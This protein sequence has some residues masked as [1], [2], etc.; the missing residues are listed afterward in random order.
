M[1]EGPEVRVTLTAEDAGVAAAIRE[2]NS[3]LKTLKTTQDRVTEST[4][5]SAGAFKS[6]AAQA[7]SAVKLRLAN[8]PG[9][10]GWGSAVALRAYEPIGKELE[11]GAGA[12]EERFGAAAIAVGGV[13]AAV[14][15]LGVAA[16]AV[17]HRM[18]ELEQSIE[19]TAAATG[20]STTQVQEFTEL[21]REMD[22]D[23][24]TLQ[25]AF[26]RMQVQLGEFMTTGKA[27]GDGS[28]YMAK[29]LSA[30]GISLADAHGNVRPLNDI[31]GDFFVILQKMPNAEARAALEAEV[32]GTRGRVLTEVFE[33]AI[34]EGTS[35][36]DVLDRIGKTGPV[37]PESELRELAQAEK[38]WEDLT[39]AALGYWT[40]LKVAMTTTVLHPVKSAEYLGGMAAL[41]TA[42]PAAAADKALS[43][44]RAQRDA[45]VAEISK[46]TPTGGATNV[47]AVMQATALN[48]T[49]KTELETL[50][51]GSKEQLELKQAEAHYAAA[52]KAHDTV[53]IG[54]YAEQISMLRQIVGLKQKVSHAAPEQA[55]KAEL[56]LGL[57]QQ[58][59]LL[60]TWKEGAA[61]RAE[62]DQESYERGTLSLEDYFAGRRAAVAEETRKEIEV[63]K[64]NRRQVEAASAE[65]GGRAS[66]AQSVLARMSPYGKPEKR[67][68]EAALVDRY[69]AE[70]LKYLE[71]IDGLNAQISI[72][73]IEAKTKFIEL[74]AQEFSTQRAQKEKVLEFIRQIE[75]LQGNVN[76]GAAAQVEARTEQMRSTLEQLRGQ[77]VGGTTLSEAN[78]NAMLSKYTNVAMAVASFSDLEKNTQQAIA[79][80]EIRKSTIETKLHDNLI[81]RVAAQQE[82]RR[83][84][85]TEIPI[86]RQKARLELE[87]AKAT[88][89][90]GKILQAQEALL[91]IQ[92]KSTQQ[93]ETYKTVLHGV[94]GTLRQ[95]FQTMFDAIGKGARSV[96]LAFGQMELGVI[97]SLENVATGLAS[98]LAVALMTDELWRISDAKTAASGAFK[99]AIH[100]LPFPINI[101]VAFASA[102]IAFEGAL[103]YAEGGL[104]DGPGGPTA[105]RVPAMLSS[106]E[107]VLR[108][109]AVDAF[110]K[111]N[112]DAINAGIATTRPGFASSIASL[113]DL[114]MPTVTF[115]D[116][117]GG[118][119]GGGD[120]F[121]HEETHLHHNGPDALEVLETQ[122]LPALTRL[123]RAGALNH[124]IKNT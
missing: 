37:I 29:A 81:T 13:T 70:H 78:I 23:A 86:L 24:G 112:L 56:A 83:L 87:A 114:R 90:P 58:E 107:Y 105:D 45:A 8:I 65:A 110:G 109:S 30:L 31:L 55:A 88:G 100:A 118:G 61:R 113:S 41:F 103:A 117:A 25:M 82:I 5:K 19:N 93:A 3:Q 51:A 17:T 22:V 99:A 97:H 38:K 49:L 40:Q 12:I 10:G 4:T 92:Q 20:L 71:Q 62:V 85:E 48:E 122:L 60:S 108:A 119:R 14:G 64:L 120:V 84:L 50:Q 54:L 59:D 52:E 32:F 57:R 35:Y 42:N 34:R 36:Q 46:P 94:S 91:E 27:A 98:N 72:K 7:L 9:L 1:P 80:L 102:A 116:L 28:Q 73:E 115:P 16:L 26:A 123:H 111:E 43:D 15:A 33:Q 66:A 79:S 44:L 47:A 21:A 89:D 77:A 69:M 63:L 2:L 124:I 53:L 76:A 74:D 11:E 106:G 96:R 101:P 95:D 68:A 6:M 104:V 121:L 18:M 75:E 67:E 39:R